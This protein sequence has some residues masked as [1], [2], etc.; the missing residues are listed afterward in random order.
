[1]SPDRMKK[2]KVMDDLQYLHYQ[3]QLEER[4]RDELLAD[5]LLLH[6]IRT[7]T[8]DSNQTSTGESK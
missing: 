6:E 5:G 4:E 2:E 8:N 3:Q 7:Q 1:M